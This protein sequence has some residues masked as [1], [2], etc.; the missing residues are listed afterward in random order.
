[1]PLLE[2]LLVRIGVLLA[3]VP[4]YS[5]VRSRH[6]INLELQLPIIEY[7]LLSSTFNTEQD[8][9][10]INWVADIEIVILIKS[11]SDNETK[12]I[13]AHS[14]IHSAL[15]ADRHLTGGGLTSENAYLY[16]DGISDIRHDDSGSQTISELTSKWTIEYRTIEDD[17]TT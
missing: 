5:V 8:F 16:T 6:H 11:N 12:L 10:I 9:S 2:S 15:Y 4:G 14:L 7:R 1:M 3:T 17:L 13:Q